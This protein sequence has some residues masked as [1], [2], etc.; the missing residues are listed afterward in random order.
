V[1]SKD[2]ELAQY[3]YLFGPVHS[4]R[5]G[6]SLGI[7]LVRQKI[8]TLNC[9]YCECGSTK[10]LTLERK[11]YVPGDK[12]IGELDSY[13][14]R[15]PSL[16][17]VTFAG[18]GEPTLNTAIGRIVRH[19]KEHFPQYKTALLTN[20]TLF[21]LP[22]V[23]E[24]VMPFDLVKPSI[25][26]VSS[27]RFFDINHPHNKLNTDLIIEGLS[28]F[29]T[30]YKGPV[31]LEVFIVPDVNDTPEELLLLKKAIKRI[32]PTRVQINTLDRPGTVDW[33]RPA[34]FD[35][36][37]EIA[38]FLLPYPVEIITRESTKLFN[39]E[40]S[41]QEMEKIRALLKKGP[42]SAEQIASSLYRII[43]E[44]VPALTSLVSSGLVV[45]REKHNRI[46][47]HLA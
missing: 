27:R 47:Y 30:K 4:R 43:N 14:G 16:D 35:R 21:Y 8:C 23:R 17:Y 32:S 3:E 5:L 40:P 37:V 11:E 15:S 28:E 12:I 13:L 45:K 26:A 20:G 36:L 10:K 7:D 22:E 24:D 33:I 19:V 25:D 44:T 2:G 34:G 9:I 31:W 42:M 29:T 6:I 1:Y 38:R 41:P 39:F 18:N 46:I